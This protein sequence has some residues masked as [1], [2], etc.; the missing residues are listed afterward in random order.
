M[1]RTVFLLPAALSAALVS[2]AGCKPGESSYAIAA[3]ASP[4]EISEGGGAKI[5]AA[6]MKN[7]S[8]E[9]DI[10]VGF[11]VA[12]CGAVSK[13][14]E[15]TNTDGNAI[16]SFTG[17]AAAD[18]DCI[19]TIT[20]QTHGLKSNTTVTVHPKP[21]DADV[22]PAAG[23]VL[24]TPVPH[25]RVDVKAREVVRGKQWQWTYL[26]T[27]KDGG[28]DRILVTSDAT[29]VVASAAGGNAAC[30]LPG[31]ECKMWKVTYSGYT[32]SAALTVDSDGKPGGNIA[33]EI[34]RGTTAAGRTE[35]YSAAVKITGPK[36]PE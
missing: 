33:L 1:Q 10:D 18:R 31:G 36:A 8:P 9:K 34:I 2:L 3:F 35:D 19:A 13:K 30:M 14:S 26:V 12:G 4:N 7:D 32:N 16:V 22:N 6:V 27:M 23:A 24:P 17:A 29:T 25:V 11:S 15:K 20:A 21:V 5:T 28:F